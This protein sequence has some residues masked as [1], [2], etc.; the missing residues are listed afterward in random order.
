MFPKKATASVT[1]IGGMFGALGGIALSFLVQKNMFVHYRS[2]GKIEIAYYIMFIVC[3]M[4]Y[5]LAWLV[6][7]FLIGKK[8]ETITV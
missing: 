4:A 7:H 1:G 8:K 2:I 6:M 5:I 3:G